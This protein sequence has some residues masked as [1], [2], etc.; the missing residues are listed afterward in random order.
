MWYRDIA[1]MEIVKELRIEKLPQRTL[2][3]EV[4]KVVLKKTLAVIS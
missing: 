1:R 2:N 4:V 3:S